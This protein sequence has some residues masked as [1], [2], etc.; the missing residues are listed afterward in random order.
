MILLSSTVYRLGGMSRGKLI[1][2]HNSEVA[3]EQEILMIPGRLK[4]PDPRQDN[5]CHNWGSI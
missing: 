2:A 1:D 3:Y 4:R 5:K